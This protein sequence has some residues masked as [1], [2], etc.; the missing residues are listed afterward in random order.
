MWVAMTDHQDTCSDAA[1]EAPVWRE[2]VDAL[3]FRP[4]GQEGLCMVHRHAFR[5]LLKRMPSPDDC[6][7]FYRA[8]RQAF[9]AA[10]RAK[11]L[12][13]DVAMSANFHLTSRDLSRQIEN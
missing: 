8:H 1:R 12:R 9:Q 4:G 2:D 5:T 11:V 13:A 10:A 3:A 7:A 6:V